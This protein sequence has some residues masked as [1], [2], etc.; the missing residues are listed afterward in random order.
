VLSQALGSILDTV[1]AN[2]GGSTQTHALVTGSAA[3][4]AVTNAC[5]PPDTDQRG[6]TRPAELFCDIGSFELAAT[7]PVICGGQSATIVGMAGDESIP[8]T[9]GPDVI[10]GLGG[11]DTIQDLA[12][13]DVLCEG[14]GNAT[15][16]AGPNNDR[17]FGEN[18]NDLVRGGG[19]PDLING[20]VGDRSSIRRSA[21]RRAN[22]RIG[23][24]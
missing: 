9:A 19:G 12:G 10:D 21:K 7:Q 6:V 11:V 14:T 5:P 18:G 3:V 20:G 16:Q 23:Y 8:G 4:D 24:G 13:N 2:N 15:V 1:L 17:A 22:R